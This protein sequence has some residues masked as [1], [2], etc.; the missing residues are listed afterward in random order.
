[1]VAH[2]TATFSFSENSGAGSIALTIPTQD[3]VAAAAHSRRESAR[4][5]AAA[6]WPLR[7]LVVELTP[8]NENLKAKSVST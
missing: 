6:Q 8:V 1:M 7:K 2:L 3:G 5:R 4:L